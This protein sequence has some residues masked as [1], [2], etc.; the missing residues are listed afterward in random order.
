MRAITRTWATAWS[1]AWSN[2][3]GFWTQVGLMFVNDTVWIV[4]WVLFFRRVGQVRGWD[5]GQ[6]LVLFAVLTTSVGF[7]LGMMNN[8][9]RLGQL[10]ADGELD[11]ALS[12]PVPTLP[13]LLVRRI[14]TLF[15]GDL[16]FGL[17][18][19]ALFG[20]PT[21]GRLVV[22][23]FGVACAVLLIT[24]FLVLLGSLSFFVG[25]NEGGELG[26]HALL[27]FSSYPVDIFTGPTKIFLYAVVPAGFVTSVP[28]RLVAE[29]DLR[30]A[31]A[32]AAISLSFAVAGWAAFSAGLHRYTSGS[33]WARS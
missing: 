10:A 6:V 2:R 28:A 31:L 17:A 20:H 16:F 33:V 18:I 3:R 14:E 4:F 9:R 13:H 22:F 8:V 30:W 32:A 25:R 29:F 7:V 21:P 11:S 15:V 5:I 27:L 24:G 1:E 12:L 26:F 19:F 23:V